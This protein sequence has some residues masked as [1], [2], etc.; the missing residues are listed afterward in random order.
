V[1]WAWPLGVPARVAH[2]LDVRAAT[3]LGIALDGPSA[4]EP[5]VVGIVLRG[6]VAVFD[7]VGELRRHIRALWR[8]RWV[9]LVTAW[10]LLLAGSTFVLLMPDRFESS[11]RIYV[12]TESLMRPLLS[13][14]AVQDDPSQQLRVM[15]ATLL[16]RPNVLQVAHSVGLALDADDEAQ[17]E[18]IVSKLQSSTSISVVNTNLF[19]VSH[20]DTNPQRAHDIVDAFL[21]IFVEAN[22]G[23]NR[24]DMEGARSFINTQLAAYEARL[25]E[26]ERR[27]ANFR[28]EHSD[29]L[30]TS[31][32][33]AARLETSRQAV[34][35]AAIRVEDSRERRERLQATLLETPQ[36]LE[37]GSVQV[38]AS[39]PVVARMQTI[40]AEL[41]RKSVV[42]SSSHPDIV[43]LQRELTS[44]K[45]RHDSSTGGSSGSSGTATGQTTVPNP[46]HEE[47]SRRLLDAE[48]ELATA[49]RR[50]AAA[51]EAQERLQ[52]VASQA[53][54]LEA[55][56]ADMDRDYEILRSTHA[57]L[58]SR[59]ESA[60]IS[61]DARIDAETIRF[62]IVEPPDV[63]VV[64]SGPNRSLFFMVVLLGSIGGGL[65]FGFILS[66]TSQSFATP[67]SLGQA[68][69]L[70]VLGSV[71]T[72]PSRLDRAKRALDTVSVSVAAG[73]MIAFSGFLVVFANDL[74][75]L[76]VE[77]DS[78]QHLTRNFIEG[79]Y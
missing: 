56:M 10:A 7:V 23:K 20:N 49:E 36:F 69:G 57:S 12:D 30:S 68:F 8:R 54:R 21:T 78:I 40:Q 64:P 75:Q 31:A 50:L 70:P 19:R 32:T 3:S 18:S 66:E 74:G 24:E 14:I 55:E 22:L 52:M 45:A 62:R 4:Y 58:L 71:C 47:I 48:A 28:S 1:R 9:V 53:P 15:Q 61:Q 13:G 43:A 2:F 35:E 29:V 67:Q 33:F 27:R 59:A 42:F 46:L 6:D 51:R 16:S 25:R 76:G 72:I 63:P 77:L 65:G 38:A 79:V 73:A 37:V 44:L 34:N 41:D 26:A 39:D 17:L 11:A 60:R 5:D